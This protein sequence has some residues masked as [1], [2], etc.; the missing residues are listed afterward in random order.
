MA[1]VNQP[2]LVRPEGWS[3]WP[4]RG[5]ESAMICTPRHELLDTFEPPPRFHGCGWATWPCE[6][7]MPAC[8]QP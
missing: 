2:C 5:R 3:A 4:T 7:A 1:I 6:S 8:D